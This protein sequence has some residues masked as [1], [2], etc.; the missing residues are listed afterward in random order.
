[1]RSRANGDNTGGFPE[2]KP[3][4]ANRYVYGTQA[5]RDISPDAMKRRAETCRLRIDTTRL[6]SRLERHA[7]GEI[8]MAMSEITAAAILLRKTLPDLIAVKSDTDAPPILF[9]FKMGQPLLA[10][11]PPQTMVTSTVSPVIEVTPTPEPTPSSTDGVP[12][13]EPKEK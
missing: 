13:P 2:V 10:K 8:K 1:M 7:L 6:L 12:E 4:R 5:R 3:H 9:N 11:E